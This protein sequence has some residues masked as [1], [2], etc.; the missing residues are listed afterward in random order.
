MGKRCIHHSVMFESPQ[1]QYDWRALLTKKKKCAIHTVN[2]LPVV[3]CVR[4][5]LPEKTLHRR[6]KQFSKFIF[7]PSLAAR[8][9]VCVLVCVTAH[10]FK[11]MSPA[12]I[13]INYHWK[14]PIHR[15]GK[16]SFM[17]QKKIH[18]N[19]ARNYE[20]TMKNKSKVITFKLLQH[21]LFIGPGFGFGLGFSWLAIASG[22]CLVKIET[23]AEPKPMFETRFEVICTIID[24]IDSMIKS[25]VLFSI[26]QTLTKWTKTDNSIEAR[27]IFLFFFLVLRPR[28]E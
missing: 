1:Q 23:R 5:N 21:L 28:H 6:I 16:Q 27:E 2:T 25:I 7:S 10:P 18:W 12:R 26:I 22:R 8:I 20:N 15:W 3:A 24:F 19:K 14:F 9:C 4:S 17:Q 11:T 13:Q